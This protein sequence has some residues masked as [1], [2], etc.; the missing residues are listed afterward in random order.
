M[1]SRERN[2]I[3]IADFIVPF[4]SIFGVVMFFPILPTLQKIFGVTIS[5]V[6]W[7]PNIGYLVMILFSPVVGS[8]IKK[9]GT[10]P[11]LLTFVFLWIF[12]ISIEILSI[13]IIKYPLFVFGRFIEA[14]GEA[15][16][17]PLVLSM[18][19]VALSS[20]DQK[21]SSTILEIGAA[22]GGLV[23]AMITGSFINEPIK[24]FLI[25]ITI[26]IIVWFFILISI[27]NAH[28]KVEEN[29]ISEDVPQDNKKIYI[30]LVLLIFSAQAIF[31]SIQVYLAYYLES[32]KAIESTGRV[33]SL[34]QI[35]G[36]V[37][38]I[39]PVILLRKLS[40]KAIRNYVFIVF[41]VSAVGIG[42]H[43]SLG[44]SILFLALTAL[45]V[46]IAFSTLNIF[47]AK[48]IHTNVSRKMSL[49]T[50]IRFLGGFLISLLW[51]RLIE[52]YAVK[53]FDYSETFKIL[54]FGIAVFALIIVI[55]SMTLQ[56]DEKTL[57]ET[58]KE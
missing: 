28:E 32:F 17:F 19:K 58:L 20:E 50:S 25:P 18:S 22:A 11:L 42:M 52:F 44:I 51:G 10:K 43:L 37:G 47:L 13:T 40:F 57:E 53:G 55:V 1:N 36:V 4:L 16:F 15:A 48:S 24:L 54:Y 27:K 41:I 39:L 21:K 14:L 9:T 56:K 7:L 3:F 2:S 6:S 26:G 5:Q 35:L 33:L 31:G 45:F 30:S 46:G 23:A 34:E 29:F 8:L 12:G 38:T 49:Y